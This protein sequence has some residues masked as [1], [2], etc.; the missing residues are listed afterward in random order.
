MWAENPQGYGF[1]KS[2]LLNFALPNASFFTHLVTSWEFVLGICL[3]LG[4]GIRIVA[5]LQIFAN[6][7]Y[8]LG[9]TYASGGANLDRLTIII[10]VTLF[11]VSAGREYGLDGWLRKRLPKLKWL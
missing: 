5:P 11:L 7:N 10:L 8:I 2:F 4:L 1:Y 9:K 6:V 3:V